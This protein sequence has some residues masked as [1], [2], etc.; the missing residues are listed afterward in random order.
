MSTDGTPIKSYRDLRP[1]HDADM[2]KGTAEKHSLDTPAYK[3]STDGR[4]L[5]VDENNVWIQRRKDWKPQEVP[6]G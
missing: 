3:Y 1:A 2:D 5:V 6:K 4:K